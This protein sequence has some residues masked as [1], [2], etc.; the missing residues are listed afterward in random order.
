MTHFSGGSRL[1]MGRFFLCLG[2]LTRAD[3]FIHECISQ[4]HLRGRPKSLGAHMFKG[5][6][7]EAATKDDEGAQPLLTKLSSL[8][9]GGGN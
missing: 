3:V 7:V 5:A 8:A 4:Q 9:D 2:V 1:T 6:D